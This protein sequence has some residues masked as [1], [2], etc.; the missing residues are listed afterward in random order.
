MVLVVKNPPAMQETGRSP[1]GGHG[2]PLQFSCLENPCAQRSLAG[3]SPQG[4]KELDKTEQLIQHAH[5]HRRQRRGQAEVGGG[6]LYW[7]NV[8]GRTQARAATS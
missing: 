6:G 1:G 7:K 4:H 3:Y 8:K 2:Y 5:T